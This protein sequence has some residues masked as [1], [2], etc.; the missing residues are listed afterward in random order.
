MS[1]AY[2]YFE[3]NKEEVLRKLR[4]VL[5]S[6]EEVLLAIVFGSLVE[7]NSYRDVDV[8]IYA[9]SKDLEYVAKLS[10]KLE[11]ELGVPVDVVPLDEISS[12]FRY[13]VLVNGIIVV[14]KISGI[15]EALLNQTLDE[16]IDLGVSFQDLPSW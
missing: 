7:L 10:A 13:N 15:Y 8:A 5:N 1:S 14:E 6:E 11:L 16:L 2:R 3:G 9:K 4:S 12:K